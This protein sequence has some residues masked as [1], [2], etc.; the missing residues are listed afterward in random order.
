MNASFQLATSY[1]VNSL[2]NNPR[3]RKLTT[4][5]D[6]NY[7]VE[8]SKKTIRKNIPIQVAFFILDYSKLHMLRFYYEFMDKFVKREDFGYAQM[9]TDSAYMSFSGPNLE[10]VVI[11]EKREEFYESYHLWFPSECCDFCRSKWVYSKCNNLAFY[12]CPECEKR[13]K[14]DKRT[15]GLFK[16]EWNGDGLIA[17]CSK[18]YYGWGGRGDKIALKGIRKNNQYRKD[19]WMSVLRGENLGHG[20]NRGFQLKGNCTVTYEMGRRFTALY[21]KRKVLSDGISTVPLDI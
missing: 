4:I 19:Y 3:Y 14:Y 6:D 17:L 10:S 1:S 9:D 21:P 7:E 13:I 12:R 11:P 15:P 2:L 18:S 8:S 5:D 20:I 16:E